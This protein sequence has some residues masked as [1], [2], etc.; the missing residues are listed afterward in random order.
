M[1][2]DEKYQSPDSQLQRNRQSKKNNDRIADQVADDGHQTAEKCDRNNEWRVREANRD[3]ENRGQYRIDQGNRDLCAHDC[4]EAAVEIAEPRRDFIAANG[5]KIVLHCVRASVRIQPS[6]EKETPSG[7]DPDNS[8]NQY[9]RSAP[10]KMRHVSQV[11][12]LFFER[13]R[14]DLSQTL[15]I[16][17]G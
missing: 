8:K 7:D 15:K 6:L 14:H 17:E 10:S 3:N 16:G 9:R 1:N 11:M 4:G 13:V 12:C 5:V 2:P